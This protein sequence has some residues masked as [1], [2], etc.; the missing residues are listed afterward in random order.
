MVGDTFLF[1]FVPSERINVLE[2]AS[3]NE[4]L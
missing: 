3:Q 1:P 2:Y 4:P